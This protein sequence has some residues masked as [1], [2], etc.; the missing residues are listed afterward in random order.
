MAAISN[1]VLKNELSD[2]AS[3]SNVVLATAATAKQ[4]QTE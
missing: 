1:R 3:T 4:S 2:V